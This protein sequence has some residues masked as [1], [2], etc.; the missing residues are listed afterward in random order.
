MTTKTV[1]LDIDTVNSIIDLLKQYQMSLNIG[2]SHIGFD[3]GK[4]GG[5]EGWSS[6]LL[7]LECKLEELDKVRPLIK[8]L[9]EVVED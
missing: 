9:E 7:D 3:L 1:K 5:V 8:T 4:T 6:I 2:V